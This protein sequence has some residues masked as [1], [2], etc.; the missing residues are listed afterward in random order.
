M[1]VGVTGSSALGQ[2]LNQTNNIRNNCLV[3]RPFPLD[4][5]F[6]RLSQRRQDEF[7]KV[8]N[9]GRRRPSF[10]RLG[11]LMTAFRA[12]FFF[13]VTRTCY[14]LIPVD[15]IEWLELIKWGP[16]LAVPFC[17]KRHWIVWRES[18][19]RLHLTEVAGRETNHQLDSVETR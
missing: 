6:R 11:K 5:S 13:G 3:C 10:L 2:S 8:W 15:V 4:E 1:K 19:Y 12:V 17:C 16:C 9:P 14:F 18:S 7:G